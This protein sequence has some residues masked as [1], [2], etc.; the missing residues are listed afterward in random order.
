MSLKEYLTSTTRF[1]CILL[2]VS[3]VFISGVDL[4][5]FGTLKTVPLAV[6][7]LLPGQTNQV[8]G[9]SAIILPPWII[10][11]FTLALWITLAFVLLLAM[12]FLVSTPRVWGKPGRAEFRHVTIP[13]DAMVEP[14]PRP[15]LN[16]K[17]EG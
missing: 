13:N 4:I 1:G 5:L 11:A 15:G 3:V 14:F 17:K 16:E 6:S 2:A 12:T 7:S 10:L 8:L 9:Q